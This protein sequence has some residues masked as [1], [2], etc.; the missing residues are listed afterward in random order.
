MVSGMNVTTI[1]EL[2]VKFKYIER[3]RVVL[4]DEKM[5]MKRVSICVIPLVEITQSNIVSI[6]FPDLCCSF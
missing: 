6:N 2:E 3:E 4:R 1:T 5:K